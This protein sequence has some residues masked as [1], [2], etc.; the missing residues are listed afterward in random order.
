MFFGVISERM[1]S[2]ICARR[3]RLRSAMAT[4]RLAACWPMMC[5][6]SS[7]TMRW[8][9]ISDMVMLTL[10]MLVPAAVVAVAADVPD[11]CGPVAR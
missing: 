1:G 7:A 6:S 8:G 9:V 2:G 10:M 5:L 4:A 3:Q 11:G